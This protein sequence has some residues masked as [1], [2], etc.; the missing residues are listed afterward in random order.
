MYVIPGK[1]AFIAHPRTASR[2]CKHA[3]LQWG[4]ERAESHHRICEKSVRDVYHE[5]GVVACAVRS[6]FDIIVSW[7]HNCNPPHAV[8][9]D[10]EKFCRDAC[11]EDSSQRYFQTPVYHYGLLYC[12]FI[13]R[14]ETLQ[15]GMDALAHRIR[16]AP[17]QLDTIGR[18]TKRKPYQEYYTP[19]LREMVEARF[20][21]DLELTNYQWEDLP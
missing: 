1:L 2:A 12:N 4:G 6:M 20:A 15:L 14:Y 5:G 8:R 21:K 19:E 7:Y 11:A 16:V 17:V 9:M 18:S 13:V 3:V 10:F